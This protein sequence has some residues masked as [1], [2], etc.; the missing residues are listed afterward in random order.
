MA[1]YAKPGTAIYRDLSLA[2]YP[3]SLHS[4]GP[5]ALVAAPLWGQNAW[6][7]RVTGDPE[8]D[9][10]TQR[11]DRLHRAAAGGAL[12]GQTLDLLLN[13]S[14][15]AERCSVVSS[16]YAST[17]ELEYLLQPLGDVVGATPCSLQHP[18]PARSDHR[19]VR[20]TVCAAAIVRCIRDW[21]ASASPH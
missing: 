8:T 12:L 16:R 11:C 13:G 9:A 18:T 14:A 6:P 10:H 1:A 2:E 3:Y 5:H 15:A 21:A 7:L 19:R 20:V 17:G 4:L